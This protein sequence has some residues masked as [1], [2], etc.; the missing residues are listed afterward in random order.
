[1]AYRKYSNV[2]HVPTFGDIEFDQIP[3]AGRLDP[4]GKDKFSGDSSLFAGF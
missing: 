4:E 2:P 3:L 1:M